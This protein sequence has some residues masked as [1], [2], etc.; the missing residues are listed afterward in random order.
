M[1]SNNVYTYNFI[2]TKAGGNYT[3]Y[4]WIMSYRYFM[5][6]FS[7]HVL[8]LWAQNKS[9]YW[10]ALNTQAGNLG[11]SF[12][13]DTSCTHLLLMSQLYRWGNRCRLSGDMSSYFTVKGVNTVKQK[14]CKIWSTIWSNGNTIML[15]QVLNKC[16]GETEKRT[17]TL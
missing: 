12:S 17:F 8:L 10:Q 7:E 11:S 1:L 2:Y 16:L 9:I 6:C 14:H 5:L 4:S 13:Y 3:G 15:C